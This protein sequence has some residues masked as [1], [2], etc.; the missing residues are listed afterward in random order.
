MQQYVNR[1]AFHNFNFISYY[2]LVWHIP[3]NFSTMRSLYPIWC[4]PLDF[5]IRYNTSIFSPRLTRSLLLCLYF[6][7]YVLITTAFFILLNSISKP[8]NVIYK[9]TSLRAFTSKYK[10]LWCYKCMRSQPLWCT[11]TI[12]PPLTRRLYSLCWCHSLNVM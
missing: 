9:I 2:K 3:L 5:L 1:A 12:T 8:K 10:T 7:C 11:Q 4:R 6:S